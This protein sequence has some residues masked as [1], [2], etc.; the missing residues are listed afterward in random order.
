[1]LLA[2][3]LHLVCLDGQVGA[4]DPTSYSSAIAT[5]TQMATAGVGEESGV[6]DLD[7]NEAAEAVAFHCERSWGWRGEG[8]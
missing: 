2:N 1:M 4:K 3:N 6:V 5:M 7:G 8:E